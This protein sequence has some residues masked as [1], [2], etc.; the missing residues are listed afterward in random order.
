MYMY[1]LDIR[2]I[3]DIQVTTG[4]PSHNSSNKRRPCETH[5]PA[6]TCDLEPLKLAIRV[7]TSIPAPTDGGQLFS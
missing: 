3:G 6:P 2:D 5:F 7:M 4:V 1:V